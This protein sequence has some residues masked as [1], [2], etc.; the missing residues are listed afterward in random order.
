MMMMMMTISMPRVSPAMAAHAVTV[1][2]LASPAAR[3]QTPWRPPGES[4]CSV[5]PQPCTPLLLADS[6][7]GLQAE[8]HAAKFTV[9]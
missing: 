9:E 3:S 4:V 7:T 5:H 2:P 6:D 8:A 1:A